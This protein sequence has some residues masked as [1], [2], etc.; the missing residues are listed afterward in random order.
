MHRGNFA[1]VYSIVLLNILIK[2]LDDGAVSLP[3]KSVDC[4]PLGGT[5]SMLENRTF[6]IGLLNLRDGMEKRRKFRAD[7]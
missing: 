3:I 1:G 7:P 2:E 5:A 6:K 4:V